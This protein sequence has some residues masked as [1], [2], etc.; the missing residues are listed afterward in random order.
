MIENNFILFLSEKDKSTRIRMIL[1]LFILLCFG[2][3]SQR[4]SA[5]QG[6]ELTFRKEKAIRV[7]ETGLFQRK[8]VIPL[9]TADS[10]LIGAN[11]SLQ[12]EGEHFFVYSNNGHVLH[13]NTKGDFLNKIGNIGIGPGEYPS[14][15]DVFV[16][17]ANK[18]VEILSNRMIQCYSY[19]GRFKESL[20]IDIPAFSFARS[21]N[22]YWFYTGNNKAYS[23]YRLF[24]TDDKFSVV[25]E[26]LNNDSRMLPMMEP[27][28]RNGAYLTFWESL[29]SDVYRITNDD[30][31]LSCSI[32]FPG[33][34]IPPDAHKM[35]PM[36]V[37]DYLKRFHFA[38]IRCY[39]ENQ[40]YVYL[41]IVENRGENIPVIYQ[42]IINKQ[43][44]HETIIQTDLLPGSYLLC[45]Q[46]LTEDNILYYIGHP[47]ENEGENV[48]LELNP[49]V[50]MID[51]SDM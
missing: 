18:S 22:R 49:S 48:N 13:F 45:P 1:C 3:S 36:E 40:K 14:I 25:R 15:T 8:T 39:M 29:Y 43:G 20:K 6:T 11:P 21:E 17:A 23:P 24:Q 46:L 19:D 9:E 31:E 47:I 51:I 41:M 10:S 12:K 33:L 38:T 50:V 34:E 32:Q 28:F 37:I 7:S 42:W 5:G 30:L 2:C 4:E 27:V 16:C 35:Q 44:G 26:Y